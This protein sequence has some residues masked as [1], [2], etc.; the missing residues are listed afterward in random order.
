M[1][2]QESR[3][4]AVLLFKA[5]EN[6]PLRD[7]HAPCDQMRRAS[8]S[9]PSNIAEGEERG[10]NNEAMRFLFIAKGSLAELRTQL[11]IGFLIGKIKKGDYENFET[12][13]DRIARLISGLIKMRKVRRVGETKGG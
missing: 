4:L 9:V 1:A 8:L 5:A 10:T 2:W 7:S 13:A 12:K 3:D 11:E 6:P